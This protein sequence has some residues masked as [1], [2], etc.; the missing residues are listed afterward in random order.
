M[1][2][3]DSKSRKRLQRKKKKTTQKNTRKKNQGKKRINS[4]EKLMKCERTWL[5]NDWMTIQF[6]KV[7]IF[8]LSYVM[9]KS[10]KKTMLTSA[11]IKVKIN[12]SKKEDID[13][14]HYNG[15]YLA[16]H[17]LGIR[18][19]SVTPFYKDCY[20]DCILSL[21]RGPKKPFLDKHFIAQIFMH[22]FFIE[23]QVTW[24]NKKTNIVTV[25]LL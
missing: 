8:F 12:N 1:E 17:Y 23:Y 3:K 2:E 14:F 6:K 5:E 4:K 13:L 19:H 15:S 20:K 25:G 11:M 9:I 21:M 22:L 24:P 18:W 16:H 10:Y 7:D